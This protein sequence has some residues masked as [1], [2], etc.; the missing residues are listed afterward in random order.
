MRPV[1]FSVLAFAIAACDDGTTGIALDFETGAATKSAP[2]TLADDFEVTRLDALVRELKLLP[3][4]DADKEDKD[5]KF[6]AKGE[7]YVDALDPR[8]SIIP[9]VP[10]PAETYKKVEFKFEKVKDGLGLDGTDAAIALD[11]TIDGVAVRLRIHDSMKVTLR[12]VDGIAL[13]SGMT[14]TF[15]LMLDVVSWFDGVDVTKLTAGNDG[16]VLI[17]KD[18]NKSAYDGVKANLT[19]AIKLVRKP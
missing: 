6:K 18:T 16:V 4:K 19:A 17:D 9:T 5:A 12:H 11:A 7:F 13:S 14:S 3:D 2:L 15:L 1:F 8:K 10:L